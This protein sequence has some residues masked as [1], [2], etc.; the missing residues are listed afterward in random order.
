MT[1]TDTRGSKC[2]MKAIPTNKGKEKSKK[3]S[4]ISCFYRIL[5]GITVLIFLASVLKPMP[6]L[7][8]CL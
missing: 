2:S 6:D 8:G 7:G 3:E 1:S 4:I 5:G